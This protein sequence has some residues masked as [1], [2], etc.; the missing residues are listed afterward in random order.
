MRFHGQRTKGVMNKKTPA[1][2][3]FPFDVSNITIG[4]RAV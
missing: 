3:A 1:Q 4:E 2:I